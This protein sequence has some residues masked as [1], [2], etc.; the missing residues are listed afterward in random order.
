MRASPR[1]SLAWLS[2]PVLLVLGACT[3]TLSLEDRPPPCL[4][5]YFPCAAT[6]RCVKIPGAEPEVDS[7]GKVQVDRRISCEFLADEVR[8]GGSLAVAVPGA[9]AESRTT[10]R[11]A[12]GELMVSV[13]G[14]FVDVV[15]NHG[16]TTGFVPDH[17]VTITSTI[18]G[19]EYIREFYVIVSPISVSPKG[20]DENPGTER[21]PFR[22][23]REAVRWAASGDIIVVGNDEWGR[24]AEPEETRTIV[25]PAGVTVSGR[26]P[27]TPRLRSL[28][29]S[30]PKKIEDPPRSPPA[31][32]LMPLA[33]EGSATL[34]NLD[35]VHRLTIDTPDAIVTLSN[36]AVHAGVTVTRKATHAT[37]S[38]TG[39]SRIYTN[40]EWLSPVLFESDDGTLSLS[41][42]T[43]I[44]H[45]PLTAQVPVLWLKGQ[46]QHL[47]VN[48]PVRIQS[49]SYPVAIQIDEAET[50]EI[51]GPPVPAEKGPDLNILGQ[52]KIVGN[53]SM[54]SVKHARFALGERGSG[55]HFADEGAGA[56]MTIEQCEFSAEGIVQDTPLGA[57]T[58]RGSAFSG[59][60]RSAIHVL[61]GTLDLGTEKQ[62]GKNAFLS[63]SEPGI[64]DPA[65]AL[66][67]ETPASLSGRVTSSASTYDGNN[68]G[69]CQILGPTPKESVVRGMW[70]LADKVAIDFY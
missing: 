3:P 10:A 55:I 40:D 27:T 45:G 70:K 41:D 18:A 20:S 11:S 58:V 32:L 68:P 44:D 49:V 46:R 8:Q 25:V 21:A 1:R 33:L 60:T 48:G 69:P 5:G 22:T 23:F 6:G 26:V 2:A 67:I 9:T 35:L 30:A 64:D 19:A 65:V 42:L 38:M 63:A 57:V 66:W 29:P 51:D 52:V 17:R 50:V 61:R 59:F 56:S 47:K 36:T 24:P 54:V 53:G 62:P 4:D 16:A 15:A 14:T 34:V 7:Q 13:R 37:L 12:S 39:A 28:D 43:N 31:F